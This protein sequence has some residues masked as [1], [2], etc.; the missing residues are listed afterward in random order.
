[1]AQ[2]KEKG[3]MDDHYLPFWEIALAYPIHNPYAIGWFGLT[4]TTAR[5]DNQ[6]FIAD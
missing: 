2:K 5:M 3:Q 4:D 6:L 1:M